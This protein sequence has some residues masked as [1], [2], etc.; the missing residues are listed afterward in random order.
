MRRWL[1]YVI[2][3][4]IVVAVVAFVIV[5]LDAPVD[6][7]RLIS[8]DTVPTKKLPDADGRG[9][10]PS[11]SEELLKLRRIHQLRPLARSEDGKKLQEL[12][13]GIYGFS[14]CGVESVRAT[15][16]AGFSL[17]VHKHHD[18][19]VYYV[20]YASD[21]DIEKY[22]ARQKNFHILMSIKPEERLSSL[23]EIPVDFVAKCEARPA[24]D[25]DRFD[26][27]VAAIPELQS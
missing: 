5:R 10:A 20:G 18:R 4:P 1:P 14:T 13:E 27:F 9:Q 19:I 22:L 3:L 21:G 7:T 24:K 23:F 12:Q 15:P 16:S 17:E 8:R 25:G 2:G 26:L 11:V 6:I